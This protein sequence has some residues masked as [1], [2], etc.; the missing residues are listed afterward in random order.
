MKTAQWC[1]VFVLSWFASEARANNKDFDVQFDDCVEYVGIG[2][3]P[4]GP[5][6]A[7]VPAQ[8]TLAGDTS[9]AVL[10]VRVVDCGAVSVDGKNARAARTAQIGVMLAGQPPGADIDNYLLWY[11]T[12]H[13]QLHGKLS[14]AGL[15]TGNDQQ[16]SFAFTPAGGAG[17]FA[18]DVGAS[19]TPVYSLDGQA[20]EPPVNPVP[21][22]ANWWSD[23]QHGQVRMHSDF[24]AISFSSAVV[25][26]TT[27]ANSEL[28]ALIG[29]TSMQFALLDSYN[30]FE[31]ALME[32]RLP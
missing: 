4:A 22:V 13:G 7:L 20:Q 8:Y 2:F 25:T 16:L 17:P 15:K 1:L 10:V 12:D 6:R 3:V 27:P 29:G 24:P 23:G 18:S 31:S 14:S 9:N 11:V 5:A 28:A 19:Q 21:F 32:V 30:G 26:L